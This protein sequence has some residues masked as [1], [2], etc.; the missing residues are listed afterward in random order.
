MNLAAR[1]RETRGLS[2]AYPRCAG[3]G[4]HAEFTLAARWRE[5]RRAWFATLVARHPAGLRM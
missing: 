4:E 3:A 5:A 2:A 1:W